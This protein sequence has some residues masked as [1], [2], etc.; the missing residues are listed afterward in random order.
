MPIAVGDIIECSIINITQYGAFVQLPDNKKGLVHI[1]EISD[2]YVNDISTVLKAGQ[3]VKAKVLT[4]GEGKI[5]LSI[6]QANE[7]GEKTYTERKNN[8]KNNSYKKDNNYENKG[9]LKKPQTFE[10]I[11]SKF[12]KDSEERQTDIKKSFESKRGSGPSKKM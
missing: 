7:N 1:S 9:D 5:S 11:L 2:K 4:V 12:M 3:L 6:K 10:D 8:F